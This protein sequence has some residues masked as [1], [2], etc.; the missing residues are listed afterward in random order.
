MFYIAL[1][2]TAGVL[3]V[4]KATS[5]AQKFT[6]VGMQKGLGGALGNLAD[7]IR[8]FGAEVREGMNEREAQLR[9]DLGLDGSHDVVD[10]P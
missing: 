6:P 3:L 7:A 10:T 9:T 2:A 5:A 1:G 4:R 8:D